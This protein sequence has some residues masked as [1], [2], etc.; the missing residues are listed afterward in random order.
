M[1]NWNFAIKVWIFLLLLAVDEKI[2]E[3]RNKSRYEYISLRKKVM[4]IYRWKF[5]IKRRYYFD[6][7]TNQ[8][9][10]L[11]D[12]WLGI[13]KHQH[14]PTSQIENMCQMVI[15]KMTFNQVSFCY[16]NRIPINTVYRSIKNQSITYIVD[17]KTNPK[18][19]QN[20]YINVDDTYRNFRVDNKKQKCKEKVLHFHQGI[21]DGKFINE[22]NAVILNKVGLDSKK[23]MTST[24]DKIKD[25]L[26]TYYGDL[27]HFN[28]FVCGDG[29]RYIKTIAHDLDAKNIL[30]SYHAVHNIDMTFS[31][32]EL[33]DFNP[34]YVGLIDG[35]FI[36]SSLKETITNL[37]KEG[38][39]VK[40]YKLLIAIVQK[41]HLVSYKLN[42]LIC[43]LRN[44]K[45]GIEMWKD[46]AYVGTA[47]ETH[48]QQYGK[49]Y[50]GN[51]GR[52]YSLESFMNIL[53][54]RCLVFFIE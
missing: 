44:H 2:C 34:N 38:E 31:T 42:G 10:Y 48:V 20:I 53:K 33:K 32:K 1:W 40:A 16:G 4:I 18:N 49:S 19:Y 11:L 22:V 45:K 26:T 50:F 54:A 36:K 17:F 27:S 51:V 37:V 35:Q 43:Y 8:Y 25:I 14:I 15:N 28:L 23:C 47:T 7:W 21:K 24:I 5:A 29:A 41:N 9:V 30:D 3:H 52:C 39:A 12:D 6:R 13:K 46:P